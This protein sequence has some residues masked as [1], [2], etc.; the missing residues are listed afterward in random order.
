M[1]RRAGRDDVELDP[2]DRQVAPHAR[3]G[4]GQ[5][6]CG[7]P[8]SENGRPGNRQG[9]WPGHD[10]ADVT[11]VQHAVDA[12]DVIKMVV[13]DRQQRDIRDAELA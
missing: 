8:T 4:A 2:P 3:G 5:P 11:A 10:L 7:K 1:K 6:A 9:E 12:S 13:T